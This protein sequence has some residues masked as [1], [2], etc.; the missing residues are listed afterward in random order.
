M[1]VRDDGYEAIEPTPDAQEQRMDHHI[2]VGNATLFPKANS[3][4]CGANVPGKPRV[5]TVYVGGLGVYRERCNETAANGQEGFTLSGGHG[6]AEPARSTPV[7][8]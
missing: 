6:A 8:T 3:Y 4:Y 5:L 2:E 7:T 1:P